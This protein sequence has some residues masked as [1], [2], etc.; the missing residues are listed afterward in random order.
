MDAHPP[1]AYTPTLG[2]A[3]T[4]TLGCAWIHTLSLFVSLVA[5]LVG[6][7]YR[8]RRAVEMWKMGVKGR[9]GGRILR[10]NFV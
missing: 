6:F 8:T 5:S 7:P 9:P 2:C 4:P 1:C 3:Y 10:G